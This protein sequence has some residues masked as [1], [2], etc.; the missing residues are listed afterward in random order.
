MAAHEAS[1]TSFAPDL[2]ERGCGEG[3]WS[4]VPISFLQAGIDA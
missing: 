2:G 1:G 4:A 3:V